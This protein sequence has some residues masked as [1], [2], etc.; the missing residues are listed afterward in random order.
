MFNNFK[1][2][3]FNSL[4]IQFNK[5]YFSYLA[6]ATPQGIKSYFVHFQIV[7]PIQTI[8]DEMTNSYGHFVQE[9]LSS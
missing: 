7:I 1:L 4:V 5:Q 9:L 8:L 2:G 3:W 6:Q